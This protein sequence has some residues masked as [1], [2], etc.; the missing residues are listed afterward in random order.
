MGVR[1]I[2]GL[3]TSCP[4]TATSRGEDPL[5]S[6]YGRVRD[7]DLWLSLYMRGM[8]QACQGLTSKEDIRIIDSFI[9]LTEMY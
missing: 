3:V 8:P 6:L 1:H 7:G 2:F 5:R 9:Y 4:H